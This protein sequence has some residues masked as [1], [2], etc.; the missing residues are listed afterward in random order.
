MKIVPQRADRFIFGG[1][2]YSILRSFGENSIFWK[3]CLA[4]TPQRQTVSAESWFSRKSYSKTPAIFNRKCHQI[5]TW[6]ASYCLWGPLEN[7]KIEK[8]HKIFF[9]KRRRVLNSPG[10]G[11]ISLIRSPSEFRY[12][13]EYFLTKKSNP[14]SLSW[15]TSPEL[16]TY[17]NL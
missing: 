14:Q 2:R 13:L 10:N 3:F 17:K 8:T 7:Q 12:S 11:E 16:L 9:W 4:G 1:I 6:A 15:M 5:A